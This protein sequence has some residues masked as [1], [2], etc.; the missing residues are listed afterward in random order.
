MSTDIVR[1]NEG[2]RAY[3]AGALHIYLA[4]CLPFMAATFIVWAVFQWLERRNERRQQKRATD[5][6]A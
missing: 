3:Q 1:W 2:K 4:I 6:L 5:D